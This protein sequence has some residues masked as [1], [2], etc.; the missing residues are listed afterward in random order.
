[1]A[2]ATLWTPITY[3]ACCRTVSRYTFDDFI[4]RHASSKSGALRNLSTELAILAS[5]STGSLPS[6]S[7]SRRNAAAIV[8]AN[9]R[10][11]VID[12]TTTN[13]QGCAL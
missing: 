5:T 6:R 9:R 11:F 2:A 10:F 8:S 12:S 13:R 3:S 4:V 7:R 1:M